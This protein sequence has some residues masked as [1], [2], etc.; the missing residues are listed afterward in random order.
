MATGNFA[1][2]LARVLVHEGGKGDDPRDPGGRTNA[3]ITHIDY[4]AYRKRKELPLRDVWDMEDNERDEIYRTRYWDAVLGDELPS[5]LDYTVFDGAVNSGVAQSVKWLQRALGNIPVDGHIGAVTLAAVVSF[6]DVQGVIKT[7][8]QARRVFLENLR[9]FSIFGKGW[10][11]RVNDVEVAALLWAT[12]TTPPPVASPATGKAKASRESGKAPPSTAPGDAIAAAAGVGLGA[13][14]LAKTQPTVAAQAPAM[15][16]ATVSV[17]AQNPASP[18]AVAQCV[19][20]NSGASSQSPALPATASPTVAQAKSASPQKISTPSPSGSGTKTTVAVHPLNML[21]N[22][23]DHQAPIVFSGLAALLVTGLF[24]SWSSRRVRALRADA[25][26]DTPLPKTVLK[27]AA[28]AS[29]GSV[30]QIMSVS[31]WAGFFKTAT[32]R[33]LSAIWILG[34]IAVNVVALAKLLQIFGIEH[35]VW[36]GPFVTLGNFYDVYAGQAFA[37]T[38]AFVSQQTGFTLP[39]WLM[40]AFVLYLSMASA[41]VVGGTVIVGRDTSAETFLGAIV[42]AGWVFAIPAFMLDAIRY[43]VVTRF[44]RQNAIVFFAYILAFSGIYAGARYV[45]EHYF[46]SPAQVDRTTAI[47]TRIRSEV[48]TLLPASGRP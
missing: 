20:C 46:A 40:P 8:L 6:A 11:K 5:G 19:P 33:V 30:L 38:S 15:P 48:L 32:A 21:F 43:R 45:N 28:P 16:A 37:V 25:L 27:L 4:D 22:I 34:T 3:G 29:A 10:I 36:H 42:H 47:I 1:L 14:V 2:A 17:P 41:F 31:R 44:A 24:L 35:E 9:T 39:L 23:V 26:G 18:S 7:A 13:A 12:S